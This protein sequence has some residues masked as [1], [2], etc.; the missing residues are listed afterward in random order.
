MQT[1]TLTKEGSA[2]LHRAMGGEYH[3]L[4]EFFGRVIVS[5]PDEIDMVLHY[6]ESCPEILTW[7]DIH[8]TL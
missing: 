3:K 2:L 7:A 1:I 4:F 5:T 6:A 8:P